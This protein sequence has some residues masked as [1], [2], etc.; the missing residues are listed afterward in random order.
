[1]LQNH[2]ADA[3]MTETY[4]DALA[5]RFQSAVPFANTCKMQITRIDVGAVEMMLPYRDEW[6]GDAERGLIHPGIVTALVDSACGSAVLSQ[7]DS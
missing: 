3:V 5:N 4:R 7:F 1:M 2:K 6:L